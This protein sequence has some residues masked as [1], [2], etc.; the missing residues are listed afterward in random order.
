LHQIHNL[1]EMYKL[2]SFIVITLL[3][4]SSCLQNNSRTE[5]S[6]DSTSSQIKSPGPPRGS[7]KLVIAFT[8]DKQGN[9]LKQTFD[10][11]A[12]TCKLELNGKTIELHQDTM[13]SGIKYSNDHYVYTSWQ[14]NTELKKDGKLIFSHKE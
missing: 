5:S 14:G 12:G 10:N 11:A 3:I 9:V 2:I 7:H 1:K 6:S 13:A 8:A 4:C